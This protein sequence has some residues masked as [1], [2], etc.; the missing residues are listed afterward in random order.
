MGVGSHLLLALVEG[1]DEE[2]LAGVQQAAR[3][4]LVV[5]KDDA[6]RCGQDNSRARV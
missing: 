2:V 1:G 4:G 3:L 5:G 6:E